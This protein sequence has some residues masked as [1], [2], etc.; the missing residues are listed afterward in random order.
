MNRDNTNPEIGPRRQ[1]FTQAITV[2]NGESFTAMDEWVQLKALNPQGVAGGYLYLLRDGQSSPQIVG[3][4]PFYVA[5]EQRYTLAFGYGAFVQRGPNRELFS[6]GPSR[7]YSDSGSA[8]RELV[9][10]TFVTPNIVAGNWAYLA[11]D[12]T[13]QTA[14]IPGVPNSFPFGWGAGNKDFAGRYYDIQCNL[15]SAKG[16][17]VYFV[18]CA[19]ADGTPT[20]GTGIAISG[21]GL[22]QTTQCTVGDDAYQLAAVGLGT[23]HSLATVKSAR[24]W[25]IAI[26]LAAPPNTME[27]FLSVIRRGF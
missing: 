3:E 16:G 12:L 15:N 2:Q 14:V 18:P 11:S 27:G 5:G 8:F 22:S 19:T 4:E 7:D 9:N 6:Q 21:A 26:S 25:T 1:I 24:L 20:S 23:N 17:T 13:W 10:G